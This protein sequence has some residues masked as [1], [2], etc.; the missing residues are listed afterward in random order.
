VG[1]AALHIPFAKP[2][3]GN[4]EDVEAYL[5]ALRKALMEAIHGGKRVQV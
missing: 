2:W 5:A 1:R 3:L 4:E